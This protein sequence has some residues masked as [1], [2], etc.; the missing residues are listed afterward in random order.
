MTTTA[1]KKFQ[2]MLWSR[3][4]VI[5]Q[6]VN[7]VTNGKR[8][9]RM[10]PILQ[11]NNDDLSLQWRSPVVTR[12][13]GTFFELASSTSPATLTSRQT[14]GSTGQWE[15]GSATR[16]AQPLWRVSGARMWSHTATSVRRPVY[17]SS[18]GLDRHTHR[19]SLCKLVSRLLHLVEGPCLATWAIMAL[20]QWCRMY[21]YQ[22]LGWVFRPLA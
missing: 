1:G 7:E 11:Y 21:N 8:S 9:S 15:N 13:S 5:V 10:N 4:L 6:N 12:S 16:P 18:G 20:V 3:F 2:N 19:Y 14:D 17:R 22:Q